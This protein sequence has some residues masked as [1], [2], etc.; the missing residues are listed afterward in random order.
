MAVIV[1]AVLSV[2]YRLDDAETLATL[3]RAWAEA[4]SGLLPTVAST[5]RRSDHCVSHEPT[6][7]LGDASAHHPNVIRAA[8]VAYGAGASDRT[9]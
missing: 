5:T 7:A 1:A 2:P 4:D 9:S 6:V 8:S 3:F